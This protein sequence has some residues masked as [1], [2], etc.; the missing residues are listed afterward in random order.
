LFVWRLPSFAGELQI[1]TC[2]VGN[3]E[4]KTGN[5]SRFSI[6][7]N[8]RDG[9][10]SSAKAHLRASDFFVSGGHQRDCSVRSGGFF[11]RRPKKRDFSA[12][13]CS[14][15]LAES[16]KQDHRSLVTKVSN[17]ADSPRREAFRHWKEKKFAYAAKCQRDVPKRS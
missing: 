16:K 5:R 12:R 14:A 11:F 9:A 15:S 10:I 4:L 2:I 7:S 17:S 3:F 1:Q 6:P 13:W 8:D